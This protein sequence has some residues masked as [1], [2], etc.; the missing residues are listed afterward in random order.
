MILSVIYAIMVYVCDELFNQF[1]MNEPIF[2]T[3]WR[4]T[5]QKRKEDI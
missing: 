5:D 3:I 2:T 1:V 4:T